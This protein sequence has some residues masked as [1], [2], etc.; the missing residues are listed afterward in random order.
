MGQE[1]TIDEHR[2]RPHVAEWR[3]PADGEAGG[4]ACLVGVGAPHG[5]G[6][7]DVRQLRDVD[8]VD[9]GHERDHG[10]PVRADEHERLDD[11]TDLAADR[12]SRV[13]R[14][15]RA[16][17]KGLD[18]DLQPGIAGRGDHAADGRVH[19]PMIERVLA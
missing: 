11:L 15:S 4:V 9:A 13:L 7:E 2:Q 3:D 10:R 5:T 12:A 6:A 14:R 17:R 18:A 8:A 19:R 16:L 1:L